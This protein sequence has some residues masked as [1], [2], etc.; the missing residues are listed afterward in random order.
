MA[1]KITSN[2]QSI[3][4]KKALRMISA[5]SSYIFEND[6]IL[7]ENEINTLKESIKVLNKVIERN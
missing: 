5:L 4:A 7:K 1:I 6:T 3:E 2:K